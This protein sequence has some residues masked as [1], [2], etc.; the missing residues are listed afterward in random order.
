MAKDDAYQ[1]ALRRIEAAKKSG[2]ESLDL[3]GLGLR[4]VPPEI[5]ELEN[6]NKGC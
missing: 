6:Q 5:G 2:T 1:I 3:S 4:D